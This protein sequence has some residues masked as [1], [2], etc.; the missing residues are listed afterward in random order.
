MRNRHTSDGRI[1]HW[2]SLPSSC[3]WRQQAAGAQQPR[4]RHASARLLRP[5][6]PQTLRS[7]PRQ[8]KAPSPIT[9][10]T[11]E[12]AKQLFA[13]VDELIKF[14]SDETGLPIKSAVKRQLTTRAAVESYLDEKF[15]EDEGA[16]RLER[17]EIVLKKFGLHRPRLRAQALPA[18]APEGA[19][20]GLLRLQDQDREPAGLGGSR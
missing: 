17:D 7:I 10:I 18:G 6:A 11:P 2:G 15:N 8:S 19:D 16:K 9:H 14:S 12:Q 1:G 5:P 13:L 4:L 3:S 20:R